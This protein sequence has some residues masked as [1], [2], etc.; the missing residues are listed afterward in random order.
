MYLELGNPLRLQSIDS[1]NTPILEL[2]AKFQVLVIDDNPPIMVDTLRRSGFVIRDLRDIETI[3]TAEPY[4]IVAC[5]IGGIGRTFRPNSN[6][7]GFYVL[8]EIRKHY[9]DKFLIQY[10]TQ[11]QYID[12][13]LTAADVIFPKDTSIDL[14]QDKLEGALKE[15]G[16]PRLRWMKLRNRL[17]AEGV[18]GYDIFKLEQAYIKGILDG[19]PDRIATDKAA[20]AL[21]PEIKSLIVKFAATTIAMGIKG[22]FS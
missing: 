19:K 4:P 21:S 11:N 9:P 6:S 12:G 13:S 1:G 8:K 15:L 20:G 2:K 17:S 22:V 14:W 18:D 5:D 7:G 3:E 16:N 10:S